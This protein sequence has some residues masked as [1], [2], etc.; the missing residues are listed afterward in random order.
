MSS[1]IRNCPNCNKEIK[2]KNLA[3]LKNA[4]KKE[5]ICLSCNAKKN[6]FTKH[7]EK[8]A[9]GLIING[10][11]NKKHSDKSLKLIS[12]SLTGKKMD[13]STKTKI[14][15]SLTGINNPMY[16]KSFYSIWVQKFG[17]DIANEK[18]KSFKVKISIANKGKNNSMYG[19]PTPNGS[20]NGI[21]GWYNDFYFRS[22]HELQF[23]LVCERF[24]FNIK[25]AEYLKIPYI[26]YDKSDRTYSPDYIINEK[27]LVEVKPK[28]LHNT[29]LNLLK[30]NVGIEYSNHN[31]LKFKVIDLG[32]PSQKIINELID[33]KKIK[34]N[35]KK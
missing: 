4:T 2:Y 19:K 27:F 10:F 25:S 21:K 5:T 22:L 32:I 18:L 20:G 11:G 23:I 26:N 16:G 12:K 3:N 14:S 17:I 31:N 33:N 9:K 1:Y 30:F 15:N 7:N 8:V 34:L 6:G 35:G 29:P 28:K 13:E 24:N